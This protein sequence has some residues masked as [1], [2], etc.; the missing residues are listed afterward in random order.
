M[1]FPAEPVFPEATVTE[2]IPL[3]REQTAV[4]TAI[5]GERLT[6]PENHLIYQLLSAAENGLSAKLFKRIREDNALAYSVGMDMAGGFHPGW[7]AFYAQTRSDRMEDTTALLLSEISR[8]GSAGLDKEEFES[9]R[10]RVLFKILKRQDSSA[11]KL[12]CALLEMFYHPEVLPNAE[13][14]IEILR[15]LT[16][17]KVNSVIG[18]SFAQAIPVTVRAGKI[19]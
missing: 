18:K 15:A 8:L 19:G 9:A 12:Y 6:D 16:L 5:R 13:R 17:E 11:G 1:E 7:F 14:E 4:V 2:N 10:E 3:E